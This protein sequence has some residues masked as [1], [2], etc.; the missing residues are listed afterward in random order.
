MGTELRSLWADGRVDL[1][2]SRIKL[3]ER[4]ESH[5]PSGGPTRRSRGRRRSSA[6][7]AAFE[8]GADACT[9]FAHL[10][11]HRHVPDG[12]TISAAC[13]RRWL[14]KSPRDLTSVPRPSCLATFSA[15]PLAS[16][17]GTIQTAIHRQ[18]LGQQGSW[19]KA[20]ILQWGR[21]GANAV[22]IPGR[23]P[24]RRLIPLRSSSTRSGMHA[25]AI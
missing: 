19:S 18:V 22:R 5:P 8:G 23:R 2:T 20:A 3:R 9:A 14:C 17:R 11:A 24:L 7:P 21:S 13:S 6:A 1:A 4:R 15:P 10:R 25:S 12:G 16:M